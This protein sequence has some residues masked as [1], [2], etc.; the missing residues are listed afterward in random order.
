MHVDSLSRAEPQRFD[1]AVVA[2]HCDVEA[3]PLASLASKPSPH[4][5]TP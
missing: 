3:M 5:P 4:R 1:R 2:K